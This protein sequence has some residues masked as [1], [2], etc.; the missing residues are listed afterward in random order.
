MR[1]MAAAIQNLK[2]H[3]YICYTFEPVES[4]VEYLLFKL[5]VLDARALSEL[6]FQ[7]EPRQGK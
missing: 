4:L 6:S 7:C 3:Q 5:N 1:K 2:K